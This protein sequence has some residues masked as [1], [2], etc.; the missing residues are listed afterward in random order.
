MDPVRKRKQLSLYRHRQVRAQV[1]LA[2]EVILI[3][4]ILQ[5]QLQQPQIEGACMG[6][7][8]GEVTAVQTVALIMIKG[9]SNSLSR[10]SMNCC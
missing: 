2:Q 6:K 5:E 7:G 3:S 1:V 4:S 10:F 8:L 9:K